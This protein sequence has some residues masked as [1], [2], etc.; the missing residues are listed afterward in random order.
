MGAPAF[1]YTPGLPA[2]APAGS[3]R[4][5]RQ[6]ERC[7][8]RRLCHQSEGRPPWPRWP[9]L[10]TEVV[11][12]SWLRGS[13]HTAGGAVTG[14][15]CCYHEPFPPKSSGNGRRGGTWPGP[16]RSGSSCPAPRTPALRPAPREATHLFGELLRLVVEVGFHQPERVDAFH[17]AEERAK[18][19]FKRG[20]A[21]FNPQHH[22][23]GPMCPHT[24]CAHVS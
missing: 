9:S 13:N 19:L 3:G 2:L 14:R 20:P 23:C 22:L 24:P 16:P 21:P 10:P 6:T 15:S 18:V 17:V 8:G 4:L 11:C 7:Q 12:A 1:P 5:W